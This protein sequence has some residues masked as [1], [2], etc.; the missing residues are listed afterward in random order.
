[1]KL[2][3]IFLILFCFA[4]G[5][6]V[7]QDNTTIDTNLSKEQISIKA[8]IAS[9]NQQLEND[10]WITRYNNYLTYRK[11]EKELQALKIS[12][13]EYVTDLTSQGREV[14]YQIKNKIKIKENELELIADFKD[15]PIGKLI[16][17]LEIEMMPTV[18]NPFKII[19]AW[20]YIKKLRENKTVY[21]NILQ[22]LQVLLAVL[23]E[24][25]EYFE[26]LMKIDLSDEIKEAYKQSTQQLLDF[27]MVVDI[28]S[29]TND[30]YAKKI[31]QVIFDTEEKITSE[32]YKT[33][34]ILSLIFALIVLSMLIKSAIRKYWQ[35]NEKY[36]V[37]NKIINFLL[38]FILCLILL[39]SYTENVGYVITILGFA[40]AG[41]AIAL[42]D[43]FMSIFG[44]F[45]IITSGSI[46]V[47]DRIKVTKNGQE[48]VGDVMDISM[49]KITVKEDIT[50][51]SYSVNR[52]T[53]RV[54]FIPNNYI[55]LEVIS[56][57]THNGFSTVWDGIDIAI[58]F[59]SNYK[60]AQKIAKDILVQYSRGYSEH[61]RK[62]YNKLKNKYVFS[63]T[64]VEPRVYTIVESY[65]VV[66][67]SWYLT[68]SYTAFGARSKVGPELL[69]AFMKEDD[70]TIAYPT[71]TIKFN[72]PRN[73]LE[74]EQNIQNITGQK[75]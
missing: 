5:E 32:S 47:G 73:I 40:S 66:I 10:I 70:I 34:K 52:R 42:K 12:Q 2:I 18:S 29:T 17:P 26:H 43:W 74:S 7:A 20:S 61:T 46:Q 24:K 31:D 62:Q 55:F 53:G 25:Q 57:Y 63:V 3:T 48:V 23:K 33:L 14:A 8:K 38:V 54:F 15:S 59:D 60:K 11:I 35:E 6:E 41:I 4:F 50:L 39:F 27:Q 16:K 69:E 9:L 30:V 28:V 1:M 72:G 45:V 37:T 67:S 75:I 68:N 71:Q 19:E 56:N 49:F 44:W 22:D 21:G 64:S 65:G 36:Y 13:K 51:T 58:T